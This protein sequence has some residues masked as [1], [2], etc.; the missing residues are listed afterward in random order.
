MNAKEALATIEVGGPRTLRWDPKTTR[1]GKK[2][3]E[4]T[5]LLATT[6]QAKG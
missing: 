5:F 4:E 6:K 2:K 1:R 3:K